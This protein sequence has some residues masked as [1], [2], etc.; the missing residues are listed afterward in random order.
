MIGNLL[1]SEKMVMYGFLKWVV[2]LIHPF[3]FRIFYSKPTSY[4]ESPHLC[5][6]PA[7]META[8]IDR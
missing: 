2:P 4:W 7:F 1:E 8:Y 3:D 5:G 6:I